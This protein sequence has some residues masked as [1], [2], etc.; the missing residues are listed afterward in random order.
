MMPNRPIHLAAA[1]P[2]GTIMAAHKARSFNGLQYL[3]EVAGGALG[4]TIGGLGPNWVDPPTSPGDRGIGHSAAVSCVLTGPAYQRIDTW[5]AWLR[6]EAAKLQRLQNV[7]IDP[8][9]RAF[10]GMCYA[11]ICV[12][13]GAIAGFV[14]GWGSHLV[15]DFGTARSLS[16]I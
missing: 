16:L 8:L 12:L 10:Y 15:L 13:S 2:A 7:T 3:S 14:A 1:I 11:V 4:G 6:H 9:V 5:Q